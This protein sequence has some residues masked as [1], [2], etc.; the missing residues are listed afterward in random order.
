MPTRTSRRAP[1]PIS[2]STTIA[3]LGPPMPVLWMV[4]SRAVGRGAR[5][6]PQPAVGVEHLHRRGEQVLG[7]PQRAARVAGQQRAL[8]DAG[9]RLQMQGRSGHGTG[10]RTRLAPAM[11]KKDKKKSKKKDNPGADAV[12]AVRSAVEKTFHATADSAQSTRTRAQDLVDEVAG[13]A[14]RLREMIEQVGVLED[15]KKQVEAL[16]RRVQALEGGGASRTAASKPAAS[17]SS[18]SKPAAR[19]RAKASAQHDP[20]ARRVAGEARLLVAPEGGVLQARLALDAQAD[21]EPLDHRQEAVLVLMADPEFDSAKEFRTVIDQIFTMMSEDPEMGPALRDADVPQRF[22]F[23]DFD[24]VV[25]I[26]AGRGR[27]GQPPLGVD[28]R[29]RLGA[30]GQDDDV[31]EDREQ[32]LPGQGERRRGDRP[33][34]HQDRRRRQGGARR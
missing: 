2:S 11:A 32:V 8:G 5:V 7:Q 20:Q 30:Q 27:R 13:A 31:L 9:V 17:R 34:A 19:S 21:H 23:D 1:S 18:A 15:L 12:G 10:H 29:R 33:P 24:L 3:V 6:A 28:R 14:V 26:R 22:E 16:A 4:S 25:N